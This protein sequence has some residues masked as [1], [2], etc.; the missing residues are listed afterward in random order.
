MPFF[1]PKKSLFSSNPFFFSQKTFFP[2]KSLL[3]PPPKKDFA[4]FW[5]DLNQLEAAGRQIGIGSGLGSAHIR[6]YP[7]SLFGGGMRR[8]RVLF[9]WD[10]FEPHKYLQSLN[11]RG[12]EGIIP[13]PLLFLGAKCGFLYL[14]REISDWK[15]NPERVLRLNGHPA[16]WKQYGFLLKSFSCLVPRS[17]QELHPTSIIVARCQRDARGA[18]GS[19]HRLDYYF[20]WGGLQHGDTELGMRM[21]DGVPQNAAASP[22]AKDAEGFD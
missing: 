17:D 14:R 3:P 13:P 16:G 7:A 2:K 20:F 10:L 21:Q 19:W 15:P 12:G 5:R 4:F 1:H 9:P 11:T 18:S 6:K 22:R 8:V